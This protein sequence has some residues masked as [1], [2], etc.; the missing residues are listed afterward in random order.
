MNEHYDLCVVGGGIQGA[1]IAQAAAINGLSVALIEKNDWGAGTSSKSSK[2]IHG[3]LR[4]LQTFEFD[5]VQESLKERRTLLNVAPDLVKPNWFYIPVYKSSFY[6]PWKISLGL[7]L[8][9]F[10]SG[11]NNLN[12]WH[13]LKKSQWDTLN[14]LNTYDLQAVYAYQ[15][16]QTDDRL[17]T[18]SVVESAKQNGA[19]LL[20]PATFEL[21]VWTDSGYRITVTTNN[22][23]Q[24][25]QARYLVNA[26]GPWVNHVSERVAPIPNQMNIDL[27]Q[28]TH[29]VFRQ[30]LGDHCFYLEAPQDQRAVFALPWKS[31]TLVGTTEKLFSGDPDHVVPSSEEVDYLLNVIRFYFPEYVHEPV[32]AWAGLRVLPASEKKPF[33][34][35]REVQLME[36]KSYIAVYGGK[37]T[38][39]RATAEKVMAIMAKDLNIKI[40]RS[41]DTMMLPA[42]SPN[43]MNLEEYN[44]E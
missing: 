30:P 12:S 21:A 32:D 40:A 27:V 4:Y 1:G 29:L 41:T 20:C 13:K 26:A 28:G 16:A 2:L 43:H 3:G 22:E 24:E 10:L 33:K 34:R 44:Q 23:H 42:L 37:L 6:R 14:G 19:T 5:L 38:A 11:K 7:G 36:D 35:S 9:S 39:Y 8:Y 17:L 25:I 15:D 31:G 18:E